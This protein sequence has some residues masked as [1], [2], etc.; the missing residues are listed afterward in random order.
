M[1]NVLSP[2]PDPAMCKVHGDG[3]NHAIARE[4]TSFSIEFINAFG[5]VTHAEEIDCFVERIGDAEPPQKDIAD[6]STDGSDTTSAA[7][8]EGGSA[9]K[10][11]QPQEG[12]R[13]MKRR[14]S[15]KNVVRAGHEESTEAERSV[16]SSECSSHSTTSPAAAASSAPVPETAM[17]RGLSSGVP[18]PGM[19]ERWEGLGGRTL[20]P[21]YEGEPLAT[22]TRKHL[23]AAA[24]APLDIDA[25]MLDDV[26]M[27]AAFPLT[28]SQGGLGGKQPV[29]G[30]SSA[31]A[32]SS[33]DAPHVHLP[34]AAVSAAGS[35]GVGLQEQE[36]DEGFHSLREHIDRMPTPA[37]PRTVD[38]TPGR[39]GYP[40]TPLSTH[41]SRLR[42]KSSRFGSPPHSGWRTP[43][44]ANPY[45]KPGNSPRRFRLAANER[46]KHMALWRTRLGTEGV[47]R[48]KPASIALQSRLSKAGADTSSVSA[49]FKRRGD[50]SGANGPSYAHEVA[51]DE[52]GVA[53][54]FGGVD[55][56]TVHAAGR[57]VKMH[58]VH[59]SVGRAGRYLLHIG[60]RQQSAMLAGS[61]FELHVSPG[62][63]HAAWTY[64]DQADLPL[65]GV[66]GQP[67]RGITLISSDRMGN[68][69]LIGG[70]KVK[71][72][73]PNQ[74]LATSV[75]DGGDGTYTIRWKS[76]VAGTYTMHVSIDGAEVGGSP[77]PVTM[78]PSKPQVGN[79]RV[80]GEGLSKAV[81]GRDAAFRI[82]SQDDFGNLCDISQLKT[83][84]YGLALVFQ[85]SDGKTGDG[86]G[87][88]RKA[89]KD[90]AKSHAEN[91]MSEQLTEK[92]RQKAL[93]REPKDSMPFTGTW[94]E[95]LYE[96]RYVAQ[97]AGSFALHVWCIPSRGERERVPGSPFSL[98]VSEGQSSSSSS[99]VRF[100]EALRDGVREVA[101][102]TEIALQMHLRDQFN[103]PATATSSELVGTLR[104]PDGEHSLD[105]RAYG[106]QVGAYET[107]HTPELRGDYEL[108][109][110]LH[111]KSLN[112]TPVEFTVTSGP[113]NGTKTHIIVPADT[114]YV[115]QQVELILEA[116]DRHGNKLDKGGA[117]VGARASGNAVGPCTVEDNKDGT[118]TIRF[119]QN[120]PGECK[121]TA[122]IDNTDVA[123]ASV[124]INPKAKSDD[125]PRR[126]STAV[127]AED[128]EDISQADDEDAVELST[129]IRAQD[130]RGSSRSSQLQRRGSRRF[131]R[132]EILATA[133]KGSN[134]SAFDSRGSS[135]KMSAFD[136]K[137][138]STKMSAFDSKSSST[139]ISAQD[140]RAST[141]MSSS[142][143]DSRGSSG[144]GS[145]VKVPPLSRRDSRSG[146]V[147]STSGAAPPSKSSS[148]R[149]SSKS[150]GGSRPKRAPGEKVTTSPTKSPTKRR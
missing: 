126:A 102:G 30:V 114:F 107:S 38:G 100:G 127:Q 22:P 108:D 51:A 27:G 56:G 60:L 29:A 131:S 13:K 147:A 12:S 45:G 124:V 150:N 130:S 112:D 113:P 90:F 144:S 34:V 138:S 104:G 39:P 72:S 125:A 141:N 74:K 10:E 55:P 15:S 11:H 33:S 71:V 85:G 3:L 9:S 103:N 93:E 47:T 61:P 142:A 32:S 24:A 101:A 54:A 119:T 48:T 64:L 66:V 145:H 28:R 139:K 21:I 87:K 149:A 53:F 63:A 83:M 133:S 16:G 18:P 31:G 118:Y 111:G 134:A 80:I 46:Q 137:S 121:V 73:C 57:L 58:S 65:S 7:A 68:R 67:S 120:A 69:C 1:L 70:A 17:A 89:E 81:A 35:K 110:A 50:M 42:K 5:N 25:G 136:S 20:T 40:H 4:P 82:Q 140:S 76:N 75:D 109:I 98:I 128:I 41:T 79:F 105:I 43:Y 106:T 95:G 14:N 62:V 88:K 86:G 49:A 132:D 78:F 6:P 129:P 2:I 92:S 123:P 146:L 94:I 99:F 122:R 148:H 19:R 37:I 8:K 143:Y 96:L 117:N 115:A 26:D 23:S 116:I 97:K 44:G 84:E 52:L 77:V 36:A 135:T 59:Y 91:A